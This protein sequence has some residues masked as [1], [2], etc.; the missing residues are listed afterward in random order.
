M[1]KLTQSFGEWIFRNHKE[2]LP[3][4]MFG[5]TELVTDEMWAQYIEW[6]QTEEGMQYLEGGSK[7]TGEL[8]G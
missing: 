4:I 2:K 1:V 6:C 3:L 8:W 5:H 7:Y